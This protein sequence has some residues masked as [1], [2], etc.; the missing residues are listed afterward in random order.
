ML[1]DSNTNARGLN[2]IWRK[3]K[4]PCEYGSDLL[5]G[6]HNYSSSE[7]KAWKK[8]RPVG[9]FNDMHDIW[10]TGAGKVSLVAYSQVLWNLNR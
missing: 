10:D 4:H 6:E 9:D 8:F 1:E 7:S 3:E 5:S 2:L